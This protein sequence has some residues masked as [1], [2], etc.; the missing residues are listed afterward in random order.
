[1]DRFQ[2]MRV[3]V[4]VVEAGSLTQAAQ[5]LQ[6]GRA[7]VT[8]LLKQLETH[9]QVRLLH[10]TTRKLSLTDEGAAYYQR[11]VQLLAGLEEAEASVG[12]ARSQPR[13]RLRIDVP[14]PFAQPVLMPALP[15]FLAR[16]PGIKLAIGASD[17]EVDVI[18]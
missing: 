15:D 10:R 18:G 16:Y 14:S 3:F 2:A 7:T 8:Q 12:R 6:L 5:T 9:L 4:R 13:G 1:M 11:A 17:R